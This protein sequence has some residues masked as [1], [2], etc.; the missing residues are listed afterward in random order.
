MKYA[1]LTDFQMLTPEITNGIIELASDVEH[2][3][4]NV[5]I[6]NGYAIRQS[7]SIEEMTKICSSPSKNTLVLYPTS[8]IHFVG[9]KKF[10]AHM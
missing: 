10:P 2:L 3:K 9:A 8:R 5:F 7:A 1:V 4:K 6:S